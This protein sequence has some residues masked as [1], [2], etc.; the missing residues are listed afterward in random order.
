M[1]GP[2]PSPEGIRIPAPEVSMVKEVYQITRYKVLALVLLCLSSLSFGQLNQ[3]ANVIF[4]PVIMTATSQ[5]SSVVHLST[6]LTGNVV[7][8]STGTITVTGTS[9][10]T[11]TFAVNGSSDGG[12]TFY[13]LN[14]STI[15][16]P[17]TTA[18]TETVT[19]AGAYQ[20]NLSGIT[21][22]EFVTSGTFTATNI[23][24]T[25]TASP[26]GVIARGGGGG[27]SFSGTTTNALTANNSGTGAPSGTTFN[28]S[29][30]ITFSYN[31]VG[32]AP[33][34]PVTVGTATGTTYYVDNL[35]GSDSNNGTSQATAW[36]TIAHVNGQTFSS[37]SQI[38]FLSTDI[39]HEQLSVPSSSITIGAYGP[40]RTCSLNS[41]LVASC[42][43]MPIIDGADVVT[44]WT[45]QSGTTYEAAYTS[46]A[47]KGFV[48][49]L[50]TQSTPL[51]LQTSIANV[52]STAGSI[53]SDGTN[54]YVHLLDGSN[55]TNHT[56]EVSGSRKY[57]IFLQ[58]EGSVTV[59]G[60]EIIRTA[61]SGYLSWGNGGAT[62]NGNIV[63]N[64]VL[65]NNGDSLGDSALGGQI[66]AAIA[67]FAS[68]T[69]IS[70]TGFQAIY[71][72]VGRMDFPH[73]SPNFALNGIYAAGLASPLIQFNKV[74]TV[75]N[76]GIHA[77]DWFTNT[78]GTCSSPS[79]DSN[80]IVNSE[81]NVF[82]AGCPNAVVEYNYI[83]DSFSAG[84]EV[85][86]G[87]NSTSLSSGVYVG[88]NTIKHDR[89]AFSNTGYNGIDVNYAING[90]AVGNVVSDV[91]NDCMTLEADTSA[92]SGWT[93]VGNQFDASQ[94]VYF[95][96]TAP[97]N[98]DRVYPIYIR[99]TSLSGGFTARSNT[100]YVNAASPFIQYG[101]T[102]S[103][104]T[105]HDVTLTTFNQ[106]QPSTP[107]LSNLFVIN[108]SDYGAI[109]DGSSHQAC[110]TLGLANLT[111]LQAYDS[112][113]YS[114]ATACTNE[115]DWLATQ[116]AVNA[117]TGSTL[118]G[119]VKIKAGTYI[120]DQ[121][122]VLPPNNDTF[123]GTA[124]GLYVEGDG[125]GGT[126]IEPSI[127]DFGANSGMISCQNPAATPQDNSGTGS[128]RYGNNGPCYG[129]LMDLTFA[130]PYTSGSVTV[131]SGSYSNGPV[132]VP[133]PR[134]SVT[135]NPVQMDGV[136]LGGRMYMH[137]VGSWGFRMGFNVM[138]D[139]MTWDQIQASNDFCGMYWAP[140]STYIQGDIVM[141]GHVFLNGKFAGICVDQSAQFNL[142]QRGELYLGFQP[143][144]IIKFAGTSATVPYGGGYFPF[145][146][147]GNFDQVQAET[148]G[149]A[150]IWDDNI[151]N[152]S[153]GVSAGVNGASITG[154][155]IE[156]LFT[157]WGTPI[158]GGGRNQYAWIGGSSIQ[159]LVLKKPFSCCGSFEQGGAGQLMGIIA[160]SGGGNYI[161]GDFYDALTAYSS[162]P[163][164]GNTNGYCPTTSIN[165]PGEFAATELFLDTS[166]GSIT[167]GQ[168]LMQLSDGNYGINDGTKPVAG[169]AAQSFTNPAGGQC[170][171]A[172]TSG[173]LIS[174]FV[175]TASG[176][177][178]NGSL[179]V[180]AASGAATVPGQAGGFLIGNAINAASPTAPWVKLDGMGSYIPPHTI[181]GTLTMTSATT[182]AATVTGATA[183]SK[184]GFTPTNATAATNI[185]TTYISSVTTNSVTVTHVTGASGGTLN[186]SCN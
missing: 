79:V 2:G 47:S 16:A 165:S 134:N 183:S 64:S 35:L 170:L 133:G 113:I 153:G 176:S 173:N 106:Q 171:V 172:I 54:V 42:T 26:N 69:D 131:T 99:N 76:F 118:G 4:S 31:T 52:N 101:A 62:G 125:Q 163:F 45:V 46:T 128:G 147:G 141:Q 136:I 174:P 184:C 138:G 67:E 157:E 36:K 179:L 169:I 13:P 41:T 139:H 94:N 186:V 19:T 159:N 14:I 152:P 91:A 25:L 84:I 88:F 123:L 80:E 124:K 5:T 53:F 97:S 23:S 37:G 110:T 109:G 149:N 59:N 55:P 150:V 175:M 32:A 137:R 148:T 18:T 43:N 140:E 58:G 78:H 129:G 56:V 61:K 17:A 48:D 177:V 57:G 9:L 103:A 161:E 65:F 82:I 181:T 10:T 111:A 130:N 28:G 146:T 27:G 92:S 96:G 50:Y 126:T 63:E 66:E 7:S 20:V 81:G 144:G 87:V 127:P 34:P 164:A 40:Q 168:A 44:G 24:L 122:V 155:T 154:L 100:L 119:I 77:G 72:W 145:I 8:Y 68:A 108:V 105:T 15:N 1:P 95:N 160:Q 115:M 120:W 11:A 71:N 107:P 12:K 180:A 162:L 98:T 116:Y 102:S 49:S 70:V 90:T 178:V 112:G 60:V 38:L 167:R 166:V 89:S 86:T 114:F 158:T 6:E 73:N 132:T 143:Y 85:G 121:T 135:G 93:V 83:H 30:A 182:D 21:D 3:Q 39:W 29:T 33:P 117:L 22:I 51:A 185:A 104:D 75:N 151:T 74:A 142:Y 156:S